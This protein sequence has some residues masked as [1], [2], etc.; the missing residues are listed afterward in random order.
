MLDS[1]EYR[2]AKG[3]V[4]SYEHSTDAIVQASQQAQQC[5]DCEEFLEK[6]IL[7]CDALQLLEVVVRDAILD[8]HLKPTPTDTALV[9]GLYTAWLTQSQRAENW[10]ASNVASGYKIK[11]LAEFQACRE[12]V[13]DW[14]ERRDWLSR[15]SKTR[16]KF[17]EELW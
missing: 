13:E 10:I 4:E 2:I 11:N 9:H 16:Q 8:G 7:A 3:R 5:A 12:R 6:G 17:A 14:L 15:A 1:L